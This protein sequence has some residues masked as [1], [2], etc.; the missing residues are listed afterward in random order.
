MDVFFFFFLRLGIQVLPSCTHIP[1]YLSYNVDNVNF[2][3]NILLMGTL[4]LEPQN[5]AYIYKYDELYL[6]DYEMVAVC[7]V[8]SNNFGGANMNKGINF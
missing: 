4:K 1:Y 7:N 2:T 8:K 5:R 3:Y 6:L